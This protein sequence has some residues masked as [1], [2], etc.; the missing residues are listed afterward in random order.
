MSQMINLGDE[1]L[2]ISPKDNRK[3]EYSVNDGRNWYMRFPGS[4]VVGEFE[5]LMDNG[6]EILANTEKGLF[7]SKNE[8]RNWYRRH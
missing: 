3:L 7:Y 6:D 2:R 8:G 1:L 4:N 5:D